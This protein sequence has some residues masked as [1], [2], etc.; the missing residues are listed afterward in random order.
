MPPKT[1][2]TPSPTSTSSITTSTISTHTYRS[3]IADGN[4]ERKSAHLPNYI[5]TP[6]PSSLGEGEG[7]MDLVVTK[8]NKT[9]GVK[10]KKK[11]TTHMRISANEMYNILSP[12][13]ISIENGN[14]SPTNPSGK[15]K[16]KRQKSSNEEAPDLN[17]H[18]I[19]IHNF[20]KKSYEDINFCDE[21]GN[22]LEIKDLEKKF[23]E[24]LEKEKITKEK[25]NNFLN[26]QI[27]FNQ[28]IKLEF[29]SII[30]GENYTKVDKIL[31]DYLIYD[32]ST[33]EFDRFD[34][35]VNLLNFIEEYNPLKNC[36]ELEG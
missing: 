8:E 22:N 27:V 28:E 4:N 5:P 30:R 31:L 29:D 33:I 12:N 25:Y 18:K 1:N 20:C 9:T 34:F 6:A 36:N 23:F 17:T 2:S 32:L 24:I 19:S 14:I 11:T 26:T 21:L 13:A 35:P 15:E 10:V 16:K 7:Y 3:I